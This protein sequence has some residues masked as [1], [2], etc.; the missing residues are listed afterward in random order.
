VDEN[1]IREFLATKYQRLVAALALISGSRPAAEDAVQEAL[2]RAWELAERG[3]QIRSPE[4]WVRT[5]AVNL[6]RSGFRRLGAE[7]RARQ[8]L[9]VAERSRPASDAADER[10]DVARALARL[11]RREREAT[12]LRYYLALS[13]EEIAATMGVSQGTA[14]TTLFRARQALAETLGEHDMEEVNDLA[15]H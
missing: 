15:G 8:A 11:P 5:V 13:V 12:V 1:A 7:R 3:E 4:A 6:I 14:K 10:V 2:A 9:G